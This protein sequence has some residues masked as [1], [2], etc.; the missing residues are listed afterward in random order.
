MFLKIYILKYYNIHINVF[1][2][3]ILIAILR[4][5]RFENLLSNVIFKKKNKM[6]SQ[7]ELFEYNVSLCAMIGPTKLSNWSRKDR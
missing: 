1:E 2:F 6:F 3:N 7:N 5:K 4:A